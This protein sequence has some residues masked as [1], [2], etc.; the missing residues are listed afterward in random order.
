MVWVVWVVWAVWVV[1]AAWAAGC[2]FHVAREHISR[3]R[4]HKRFEK[5]LS[6]SPYQRV[7]RIEIPF[8]FVWA[9]E[10]AEVR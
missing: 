1:V 10:H 6:L 4:N 2:K 8:L 3:V 5:D 9:A 7:S